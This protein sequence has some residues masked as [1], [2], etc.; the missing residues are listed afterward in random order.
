MGRIIRPTDQREAELLAR[1]AILEKALEF[2]IERLHQNW[3]AH[4]GRPNWRGCHNKYCRFAAELLK[5]GQDVQDG[6]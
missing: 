5:G 4:D 3:I 6:K 1:I 2:T